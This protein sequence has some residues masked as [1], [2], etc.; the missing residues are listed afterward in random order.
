MAPCPCGSGAAL[1]KCCGP[2]ISGET[3]AP[4]AEALMR[5]RYTAFA[6]GALDHIERTYAAD[7]RAEFDH[8][9]TE[10]TAQPIQWLGLQIID[11]ALGGATDQTGTVEFAARYRK[12]GKVLVHRERSNF[13]RENDHWVYAD[14][15]VTAAVAPKPSGK[16]G[17]NDPCPCG[18]G[19]KFK[20]CCGA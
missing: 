20:K 12:D 9:S 17:R 14:G 8:A 6:T 13:V 4:T 18:S 3:P 7:R 2:I 19:K 16:I 10:E 11:T 15:H 1:E 5:S